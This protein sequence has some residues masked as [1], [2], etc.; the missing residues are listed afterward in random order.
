[1]HE[2][3]RSLSVGGSESLGRSVRREEKWVLVVG[4]SLL[5]VGIRVR[6]EVDSFTGRW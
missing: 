2:F 6:P 4:E 5:S 1:M 3:R